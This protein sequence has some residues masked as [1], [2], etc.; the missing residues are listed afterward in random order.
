MS[1]DID[2]FFF[3][4]KTDQR[5]E[6]E[7]EVELWLLNR[8]NSSFYF[9]SFGS[10]ILDFENK[11]LTKVNE[12]LLKYYITKAIADMDT[13][14]TDG[15]NNMRDRRVLTSQNEITV[16]SN[17]QNIDIQIPYIPMYNTGSREQTNITL[18][19]L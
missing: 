1:V 6:I 3:Y 15:S 8:R 13:Y 19:G 12:M 7:Q 9:R 10:E 14:T 17:G 18:G 2:Q 16:T 11:P 4:G 5:V